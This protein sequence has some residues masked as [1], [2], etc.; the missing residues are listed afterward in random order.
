MWVVQSWDSLVLCTADTKKPSLTRDTQS[1]CAGWT[2]QRCWISWNNTQLKNSTFWL[3]LTLFLKFWLFFRSERWPILSKESHYV[4]SRVTPFWFQRW[5]RPNTQWYSKAV[6]MKAGATTDEK[7]W[8][9]NKVK[10]TIPQ[11]KYLCVSSSMLPRDEM[12]QITAQNSTKWNDTV[13][14]SKTGGVRAEQ[15]WK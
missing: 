11:L 10:F 2:R 4:F 5:V 7:W 6:G 8:R 15:K 12:Q 3:F 13:Q 14:Q 1:C 9:K